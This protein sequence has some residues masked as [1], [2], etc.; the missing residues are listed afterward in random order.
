MFLCAVRINAELT[1]KNEK[2]IHKVCVYERAT[3]TDLRLARDDRDRVVI[4][5]LDDV[6]L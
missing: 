4:V 1:S 3:F 5:V 2:W 6:C